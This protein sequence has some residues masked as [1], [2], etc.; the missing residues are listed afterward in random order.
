MDKIKR[1]FLSL[2]CLSAT[3]ASFFSIE[4]FLLG[5][6][7]LACFIASIYMFFIPEYFQKN[8]FGFNI[9]KNRIGNILNFC[10]LSIITIIIVCH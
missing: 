10:I 7:S 8:I 6:I 2:I 9:S 5:T 4:S 3:G 1:I